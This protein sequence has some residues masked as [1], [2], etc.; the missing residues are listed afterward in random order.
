[1][2]ELTRARLAIATL[3]WAVLA[4]AVWF[5]LSLSIRLNQLIAWTIFALL[6]A[7]S[8][9]LAVAVGRY[10]L[11]GLRKPKWVLLAA[12]VAFLL[13]ARLGALQ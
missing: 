12:F 1:M 4:A 10:S 8:A 7:T 13:A 9:F 2:A 11:R 6:V 3:Q 5:Y